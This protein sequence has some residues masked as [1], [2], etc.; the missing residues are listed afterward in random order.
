[1]NVIDAITSRKSVRKY[2]DMPIEPEK[3]ERVLEAGRLAPTARNKQ[4]FKIIVIKDKEMRASLTDALYGQKFATD[5][6]VLLV[7]VSTDPNRIM[8]C[9]QPATIIDSSI[10]LS[11]MILKAVEEG[12]G[13]CWLGSFYQDKVK[14]ILNVPDE[15][16]VVCMTPLGYPEDEPKGTPRKE[17]KDIISEEKFK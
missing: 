4:D 9:D 1:M 17:L 12:L 6:P 7:V 11:F 2:K 13:T 5:A 14:D 3:L 8:R 15:Y 16:S 10:V